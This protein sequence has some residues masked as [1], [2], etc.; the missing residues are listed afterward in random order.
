MVDNLVRFADSLECHNACSDVTMRSE[1]CCCWETACKAAGTT[2]FTS[3]AIPQAVKFASKPLGYNFEE[4]ATVRCDN[5]HDTRK[6]SEAVE[7]AALAELRKHPDMHPLIEA[8][9]NRNKPLV[10]TR[11]A[12]GGDGDTRPE[13]EL[14]IEDLHLPKFQAILALLV[15]QANNH[16][17]GHHASCFKTSTVTRKLGCR[18]GFPQNCQYIT[19]LFINDLAFTATEVW[20][21]TQMFIHKAVI[22]GMMG[23][24]WGSRS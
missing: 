24:K 13:V 21:Y 14:V 16:R 7:R 22:G 20:V 10:R 17:A 4:P 2:T 12:G 1:N 5:C 23:L 9:T 19:T 8:W 18:Y 6:G 15:L 11:A 3:Q